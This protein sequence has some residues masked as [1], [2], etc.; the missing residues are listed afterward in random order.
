MATPALVSET[1]VRPA[2]WPRALLLLGRVALGII[3]IYAAYT[4]LYFN[5]GWHFPVE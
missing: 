4:K 2:V 5:G 1:Y 3:F